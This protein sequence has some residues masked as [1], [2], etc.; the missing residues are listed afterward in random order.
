[1]VPGYDVIRSWNV[2]TEYLFGFGLAFA[3]KFRNNPDPYRMINHKFGDVSSIEGG[4]Q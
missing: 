4:A 3:W 2:K 1:M